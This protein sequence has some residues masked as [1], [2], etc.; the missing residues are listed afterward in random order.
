M[1]KTRHSVVHHPLGV[2]VETHFR[3]RQ[4]PCIYTLSTVRVYREKVAFV[5]AFGGSTENLGLYCLPPP[6]S[7]ARNSNDQVM[8]L[9][10]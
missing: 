8:G 1:R 7:V 10:G 3:D 4:H 5:L 9:G 2:P 6:S